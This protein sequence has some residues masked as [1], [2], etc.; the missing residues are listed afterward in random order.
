LRNRL[1][2]EGVSRFTGLLGGSGNTGF[3]VVFN[4]DGGRGHAAVSSDGEIVARSC[5]SHLRRSC[6]GV[7]VWQF[8]S[9]HFNQSPIL[10]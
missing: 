9:H 6:A 1:K 4:S 10:D 7:K 5:Y 2:N 3:E 8:C